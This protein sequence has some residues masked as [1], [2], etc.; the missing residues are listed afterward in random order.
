MI[1]MTL[2]T[3]EAS[4]TETTVSVQV[5]KIGKRQLTQRVFRQIH[6]QQIIDHKTCSLKGIPW[7]HVNYFWSSEYHTGKDH[8]LWVN[9]KGELRRCYVINDYSYWATHHCHS[10]KKLAFDLLEL[11]QLYIAT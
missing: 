7:G 2:N 9:D 4:I 8:I 5:V 11:P 3:T 10:C 6:R 1:Y